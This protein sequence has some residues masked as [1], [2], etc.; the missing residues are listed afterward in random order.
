MGEHYAQRRISQ[1]RGHSTELEFGVHIRNAPD[2]APGHRYDR[3]LMASL[4]RPDIPIASSC[5][6]WL[7]VAPAPADESSCQPMSPVDVQ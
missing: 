5:C 4:T 7:A 3:H 2:M 1:D 6:M